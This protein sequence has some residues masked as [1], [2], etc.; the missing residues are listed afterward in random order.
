MGADL[1]IIPQHDRAKA[2]VRTKHGHEYWKTDAGRA[3]MEAAE[4][5][6][7]FRDSYNATSV[8]NTLGLSWW[9]DVVPMLDADQMLA[10]KA[11]QRVRDM[12]AAAAQKLPDASELRARH[13]LVDDEEASVESWHGYFA[14][15]RQA[16]IEFFDRAIANGSGVRCSL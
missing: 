12:I 11:L 13:A 2:E 14:K 16:L 10:G 8:L 1:Y 3:A 5:D 4:A 6:W 15:K 9:R 7:Y